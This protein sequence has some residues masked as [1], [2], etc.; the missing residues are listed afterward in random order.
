MCALCSAY[1]GFIDADDGFPP[2]GRQAAGEEH[3]ADLG[4]HI[5]SSYSLI[6]WLT[7]HPQQFNQVSSASQQ[8]CL[9]FAWAF[10]CTPTQLIE[11]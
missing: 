1:L 7:M 5:L 3:L 6:T 9:R 8:K 10:K 11:F 2:R 4:C